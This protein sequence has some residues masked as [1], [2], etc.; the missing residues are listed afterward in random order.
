MSNSLPLRRLTGAVC[1]AAALTAC[2]EP[3]ATRQ[4]S[5]R[6]MVGLTLVKPFDPRSTLLDPGAPGLLVVCSAG[7]P[8]TFSASASPARGTLLGGGTFSVADGA[9]A[10]AWTAD[11]GDLTRVKI[12]VTQ[13]A[14]NFDYIEATATPVEGLPFMTVD[15][16]NQRITWETNADHGGSATFF[17]SAPP[18][19]EAK[20]VVV[21]KEGPAGTYE[22][23]VSSVGGTGDVFPNGETFTLAA[24]ECKDAWTTTYQPIDPLVT[25]TELG[26]AP[27]DSIRKAPQDSAA[28]ILT[29]TRAVT[30]QVNYYHGAVVT[31]FNSK[32]ED[33]AATNFGGAPP[34]TYP[35]V[36]ANCVAI[37][38]VQGVAITPVT[39]TGSGGAGGPYTF[40]AT[41]L[42]A[43]LVIS[44]SG[45]ISGTPTVSGTFAYTVTVTDKNGNSGTVDCAVVGNPPPTASCVA[46]TAVQGKAITPVT[47]TGSGGTGGPYTFSATGLPAGLT[48]SS[49]GTISG[50]P[51]VSGTFTYTVTVTDKDGHT[52]TIDCSVVV[53][54]PV[55]GNCVAIT[56][57]QGKAITPVTLT[58]SGGTGGP[59]T[60][61]AT[62]LPAGLTM[63]S[64]GTISG[65]PTVSGTF[66]YTVTVTDKDGHTGTIDCSVVVNPPVSGNCVAITAVQ[67]RAIT[68]VTLTGSGGAGGPYTFSA[69]GLPAGLTMS[70]S[71]TISGTPTVSGTFAYTVTVTD[72][73]GNSGSFNCSVVV[74]PPVS[75]NCVAITAEQGKAITPVTLTGS[76]G[77]GGPYTFSA[78]GLPAGLT[79]SSS[80][81]ISGTPTVTGTFTYTVTVTD[82]DGN[83]GTINCS[84]TVSP[85]PAQLCSYTQGGWGAPPNGGNIANT[86]KAKFSTVFPSGVTIGITGVSGKFSAKFTSASA[87]EAY[88]P[89]GGTPGV[90]TKNYT[91]PL[92]TS[93]NVFGGQVLALQLSVSFSN[94]G[95]IKPG[96]GAAV[97][98]SGALAG[99]TVNQVLALAN[100]VIGGN[101]SALTPYGLTVSGL[102]DIVSRINESMDGC[103]TNT[104]YVK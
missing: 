94:A 56:A 59:Y 27:L 98:Q 4:S 67:G 54:P 58:G 83:S 62:G 20:K 72:K 12:T 96:L 40:S 9:C 3:M 6:P 80:G 74:N 25:V 17:Q 81:T 103:T 23:S 52:G 21:C 24:G 85:P 28:S 15:Q 86:L 29:G 76:G 11:A 69:T 30:S 7:G 39:L 2:R 64:S 93:A 8:A 60:F 16:G 49:S 57:V 70:S 73:D 31:Y 65:T 91:N 101:T 44:A 92:T 13:T 61:S 14:G 99:L 5:A 55:S 68:P 42:P 89:A 87:I 47:L 97:V 48:M 100:S 37:T 34:C 19:S 43:G 36:V 18:P 1:V 51:T 84:V 78:T 33:P 50:T 95:V 77:A 45:T 82:K 26:D 41:G 53:N 22:F 46:I 10:T 35:P 75:G 71:G 32:C 102:N 90:L 66:T 88:L 63:S 38:A 104:G 79:M